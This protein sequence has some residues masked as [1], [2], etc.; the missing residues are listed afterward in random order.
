MPR[1]RKKQMYFIICLSIAQ[2]QHIYKKNECIQ[3]SVHMFVY[4]YE[5]RRKKYIFYFI[6]T[7]SRII[8]NIKI[9]YV[10]IYKVLY[11]LANEVW[12]GIMMQWNIVFSLFLFFFCIFFPF[13]VLNVAVD[14]I[15]WK[16]EFRMFVWW[17][18]GV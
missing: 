16:S 13:F 4:L 18:F 1:V 2:A 9:R 10:L 7:Y 5:Y 6:W 15:S 3:Y 14:S 17:G 11:T 12:A 8:Y